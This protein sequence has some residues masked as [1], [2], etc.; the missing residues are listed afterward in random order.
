MEPDFDEDMFC[1]ICA[2]VE[3]ISTDSAENEVAAGRD[4]TLPGS[5]LPNLRYILRDSVHAARRV[6]TRPW[7]ADEVLGYVMGFLFQWPDSIGQLVHHSR[8][9]TTMFE[10]SCKKC[11]SENTSTTFRNL[12]TAKHRIESEITPPSRLAL[13]SAV[14]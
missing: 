8:H 4:L 10:E 5:F 1:A 9:M 6:L 13:Y 11:A 14:F 12:H 2:K 7:Q 3:A